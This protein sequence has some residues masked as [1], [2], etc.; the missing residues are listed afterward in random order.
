MSRSIVIWFDGYSEARSLAQFK[1]E[2]KKIAGVSA[3][4]FV[5]WR[6]AS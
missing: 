5:Q 2:K 4:Q 6:T 3:K 1:I